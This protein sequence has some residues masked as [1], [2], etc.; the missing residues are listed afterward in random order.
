[1]FHPV[2]LDSKPSTAFQL[3]RK[4]SVST[5]IENVSDDMSWCANKNLCQRENWLWKNCWRYYSGVKIQ[6]KT[7]SR[8]AWHVTEHDGRSRY[9]SGRI[10]YFGKIIA[11]NFQIW[12]IKSTKIH[13]TDKARV[14]L[15]VNPERAVQ[16]WRNTIKQWE[17][18]KGSYTRKSTMPSSHPIHVYHDA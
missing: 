16:N 9:L 5:N 12:G 15:A 14:F 7:Y 6:S 13:V 8:K 11:V 18:A 1:M 3:W 10:T 2:N 17:I 4:S